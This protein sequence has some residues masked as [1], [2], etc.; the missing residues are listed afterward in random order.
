[1]ERWRIYMTWKCIASAKPNT[2]TEKSIFHQQTLHSNR[3][4]NRQYTSLD[5]VWAKASTLVQFTWEFKQ[6]PP[7]IC[8]SL[9]CLQTLVLCGFFP[10]NTR[11]NHSFCMFQSSAQRTSR[12]CNKAQ[13][14]VKCS[15]CYQMVRIQCA[16][17][18]K[19]QQTEKYKQHSHSSTMW[20]DGEWKK[21]RESAYRVI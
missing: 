14:H 19:K 7:M 9:F 3:G 4:Q 6:I 10:L 20:Y 11:T 16:I 17:T 21:A 8:F 5:R 13:T 15:L 12:G 18:T 1:M 2:N